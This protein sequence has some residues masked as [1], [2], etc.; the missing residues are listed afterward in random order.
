MIEL[1]NLKIELNNQKSSLEEIYNSLD[2]DKK[3]NRII[4]INKLMEDSNFWNNVE[5]ANAISKE[6]KEITSSIDSYKKLNTTYTL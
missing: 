1:D 4:E 3:N 6:L 5:K 2:I